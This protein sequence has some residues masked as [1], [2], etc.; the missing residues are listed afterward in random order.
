MKNDESSNNLINVLAFSHLPEVEFTR[1]Q[2]ACVSNGVSKSSVSR[3]QSAPADVSW[4]S[5]NQGLRDVDMSRS[6]IFHLN[7]YFI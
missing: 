6:N 5:A 3:A 1:Q 2:R 7:K 4:P